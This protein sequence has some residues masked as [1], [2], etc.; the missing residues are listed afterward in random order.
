M[1]LSLI[2]NNLLTIANAGE[3]LNCDIG[4]EISSEIGHYK[5]GNCSNGRFSKSKGELL[6]I[7]NLQAALVILNIYHRS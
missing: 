2:L 7:K 5:I 6:M 3:S 1:K 4:R